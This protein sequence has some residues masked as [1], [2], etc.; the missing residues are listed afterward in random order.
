MWPAISFASASETQA[1][2]YSVDETE[3]EFTEGDSGL[4]A[5]VSLLL[6]DSLED[7]EEVQFL[8][9][10]WFSGEDFPSFVIDNIYV[11]SDEQFATNPTP[12]TLPFSLDFGS[13]LDAFADGDSDDA[14]HALLDLGMVAMRS[15]AG[16]VTDKEGAMVAPYEDAF[17]ETGIT[18][19]PSSQHFQTFLAEEGDVEFLMGASSSRGSALMLAISTVG[20]A[21]IVLTYELRITEIDGEL[22]GNTLQY[23]IGESGLF[24]D[25]PHTVLTSDVLDSGD[26]YEITAVLPNSV[27]NEPVV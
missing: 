23:R 27:A 1:L 17:I 22:I 13:E 25:L 9:L 15:R 20:Y 5:T 16:R 14:S 3:V 8:W 18:E 19:L 21:D 11:A 4:V 2:F 26:V 7:K 6:P 10:N 12:A 24:I